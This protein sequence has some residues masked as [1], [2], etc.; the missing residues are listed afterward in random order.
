MLASVGVA[1]EAV[2]I[3]ALGALVLVVASSVRADRSLLVLR[4]RRIEQALPDAL[5]L[6]AGV[7]EAGSPLDAALA[8]VAAESDGPLAVELAQ[9]A[10]DLRAS[11]APRRDAFVS[12]ARAGV[13]DL[14][15]IGHALAT[16]D[17]LGAPITSLLREQA[18][19]QRELDR[20]RIR[21]RAASASP[22]IAL[23]VS[24]LLVPSGLLMVLGSQALAVLASV[25]G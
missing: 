18:S 21:A 12:L 14:A 3:C 13:P 10:A 8:A 5:D 17:E 4:R 23:V 24:F 7:V 6:L 22:K 19:L 2:L 16:A 11:H 1:G 15:R 25:R 20:L 9:C